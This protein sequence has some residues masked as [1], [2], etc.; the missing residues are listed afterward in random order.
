MDEVVLHAMAR[1]KAAGPSIAIRGAVTV[2]DP[3]SKRPCNEGGE[4]TD[5]NEQHQS[6]LPEGDAQDGQRDR[7]Q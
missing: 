5:R 1:C 2:E 3:F 4:G 6:E 7:R